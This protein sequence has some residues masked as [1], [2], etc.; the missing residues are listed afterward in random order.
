MI[1]DIPGLEILDEIGQGAR[2]VVYRGRLRGR[3]VAVKFPRRRREL[4]KVY[5]E[6]LCESALQGRVHHPGLLQ[7]YEVGRH[8][9]LPFLV[10]ELAEPL[11][12]SEVLKR[13]P[14]SPEAALDLGR[15]LAA[16]LAAVHERG[17]VHRDVK[18]AN[19]LIGTA[20]QAHLI[21]FGLTTRQRV[22]PALSATGTF[23]YSAPEQTGMLNRPLD[24]RADLYALGVVLYECVLGSPPFRSE[25]PGE[26]M[27][28]HATRKPPELPE[29][30]PGLLREA[31][32]R[33]LAKDPADRFP[34]ARQL[35]AFL[36]G[37][38][39][40]PF[41]QRLPLIGRQAQS[42]ALVQHWR[43]C[44][45]GGRV[46]LV[47]G[48]PGIGKTALLSDFLR[49]QREQIIVRAACSPDDPPYAV[50]K[51]LLA[52]IARPLSQMP[53]LVSELR[54]AAGA[55]LA[56]L[57]DFSPALGQLLGQSGGQ[58]EEDPVHHLLA[59]AQFLL[60]AASLRPIL[61]V[62]EDLHWAD[63]SSLK[64]LRTVAEGWKTSHSLLVLSSAK[65]LELQ[66]KNLLELENLD[67]AS[68]QQLIEAYLG[69]C[70]DPQLFEQLQLASG[71]NPLAALT[72]LET[73]LDSGR[74]V[75]HWGRWRLIG[76]GLE[77]PGDALETLVTR[78][79]NLDEHPLRLL[80]R[81]AVLGLQF[82][83]QD[84]EQEE[85]AA[86]GLLAEAR[87]MRL[88]E[89]LEGDHFR[90]LHERL[91]SA[92]L[93]RLSPQQL[94]ELHASAAAGLGPDQVFRRAQHL[95]QSAPLPDQAACDQAQ[96][97][98]GLL[99]C[100]Q[101]AY[102]EA[103][104]FFKRLKA[105][106]DGESRAAFGYAC[107]QTGRFRESLEHL[108]AALSLQTSGLDRARARQRLA[109][110][111]MV[112]MDTPRA[113]TEVCAGLNEL[114]IRVGSVPALMA[115]LIRL[116]LSPLG[117][118]QEPS[119]KVA[120]R[121]FET[122]SQ[123]CFIAGYVPQ[124]VEMVVRGLRQARKLG[125]TP[126]LA[127]FYASAA[128][129]MAAA[130]LG[131][132]AVHYCRKSQNLA[133]ELQDA[134]AI[135]QCQVL[136]SVALR[137]QGQESLAASNTA[138][139]LLERGAW[140]PTLD[141]LFG[142]VD[143]TH[144]YHFRGLLARA[145]ETA[146]L[147]QERVRQDH[148]PLVLTSTL[149]PVYSAVGRH[150]EARQYKEICKRYFGNE[151]NP[152]IRSAYLVSSLHAEMER[153]ELGEEVEA[154][155]EQHTRL[156][157]NPDTGPMHLRTFRI[158]EGYLRYRQAMADRSR[159]EPLRQALKRLRRHRA[160]SLF[161]THYRVLE[162]GLAR[163][164]GHPARARR[165]LSEAEER[166]QA[167]ENYWVMI[168]VAKQKAALLRDQER[169]EAAHL[170]ARAA[171][172]MAAELGWLAQLHRIEAEFGLSLRSQSASGRD[173]D[174]QSAL[175]LRLQRNLKALLDMTQATAQVLDVARV[176]DL[177]LVE[178]MRILSAE[179]AM[180]FLV[181]GEDLRF[182]C[183]RNE[184]G[185]ILS[186]NHDYAQ[187]VLMQVKEK[188]RA[189]LINAEQDGRTL[190]HGL[191]SILAAPLLWRDRLV[192]V[193]YLD[194]RLARGAFSHEDVEVLQALANQV[195]VSLETA[196]S[197]RLELQVRGERD[198][199]L[200]AEQLS[201]MVGS[202]L[203]HLDTQEILT[204][205]LDGLQRIVGFDQ[206]LTRL[207]AEED[208]DTELLQSNRPLL[209]QQG[210]WLGAALPSPSGP[211]GHI[212][213]QRDR[214][215][216]R[217]EAEMVQT[218]VSYAGIALENS[219]LFASVQRM[220]TIDELTGILNRRQ[221]LKQAQDELYRADRLGHA[222]SLV[223][224]DVDHF[225]KF[226]DTHGHAIGDLVLRTVAGR[227]RDC[228]RGIDHLGRLGG[229]E[230]AVLLVGTGLEPGRATADRLRLAICQQSFASSDGDLQVSISL[231]V[232]QR[233]PQESLDALLERADQA[234]YAA[235]RGGRNQVQAG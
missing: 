33:L 220:A 155:I 157:L 41:S 213:L 28:L 197:A 145:H 98:A 188:A 29:H 117:R 71:G 160:H 114:G 225:K 180:L 51:R 156:A 131:R 77:L 169:F 139:C 80:Q 201:E 105:D 128:I 66:V 111:H 119:D 235:K 1:P 214:P 134:T 99:A 234:L 37:Q 63:P 185:Q 130:G 25:D 182:Q 70:S 12:L 57:S 122:G 184:Q 107:Y 112:E 127:G 164:S 195:A 196:R 84:L 147:G 74:L 148:F 115:D 46:V 173:S 56:L 78:V 153:G 83:V 166:A 108:Q 132:L 126:S 140:L 68:L 92:L 198:Q 59:L 224:F 14:Y 65:A 48:P 143:L 15:Q 97:Q 149:S 123:I 102:Q 42:Q 31:V 223:M 17:L 189:T 181:E 76:S 186:L 207:L 35:Y 179:R 43:A 146:Q 215:F 40:L 30:M 212:I 23:S 6:Y 168:E 16:T 75:P 136:S 3:L 39:P 218:V 233:Q 89:K 8:Q 183:G 192:G 19:I 219:Q 9:G 36:E 177:V 110:V 73:A 171:A 165:L 120:V 34:S 217:A 4:D 191:R 135:A 109:L 72:V 55:N 151:S 95:W 85:S 227:C 101:H 58:R 113:W 54:Q 208:L 67:E 118:S 152:L 94:R 69:D 38:P 129:L 230:F 174:H 5:Q 49:G 20:G 79:Q 81:A 7:V 10:Q 209:R 216:S 229:E 90:F 116:S 61:V 231:G 194:N 88:I 204:R 53:E 154:L 22:S 232:A 222:L 167:T 2:N 32:K 199:R 162:A 96:R 26:L 161:D 226:N 170:Q 44:P 27:H 50:L 138:R 47:S 205:V 178:V 202:L 172:A 150:A 144:N 87:R 82:R 228:L 221:F 100:Q 187:D 190:S 86:H 158:L 106:Q 52:S 210:L 200:L 206:A 193:M 104:D 13:G 64:V 203:T 45:Q 211:L 60:Q 93:E 62:V 175:T 103:Y 11:P 125:P 24:G 141:Y 121:L 133:E 163:L 124:L 91:R 18:P 176:S 142:V 137:F 21:D 159:L